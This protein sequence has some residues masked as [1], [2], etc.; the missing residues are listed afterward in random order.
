LC[1]RSSAEI[2]RRRV[3]AWDTS[4]KGKSESH[5]SLELEKDR[6]A[7][8]GEQSQATGGISANA[9]TTFPRQRVRYFTFRIT[10]LTHWNEFFLL[11]LEEEVWVVNYS[12]EI[13]CFY[14]T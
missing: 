2:V 1:F 10:L 8:T 4:G 5:R 3:V 6:C 11:T 9:S 14:V 7:N 13:P 12:A